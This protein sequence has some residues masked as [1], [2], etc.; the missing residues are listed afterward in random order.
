MLNRIH[1][2]DK[3]EDSAY[4]PKNGAFELQSIKKDAESVMKSTFENIPFL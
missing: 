3:S 2:E 4:H 1:K